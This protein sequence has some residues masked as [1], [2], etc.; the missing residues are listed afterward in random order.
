VRKNQNSLGSS[1]EVVPY[2][3]ANWYSEIGAQ[4]KLFQLEK[5]GLPNFYNWRFVTLTVD[6]LKFNSE[7]SAYEHIKERMRYFIR[8]LKSFL[9]ISELQY[10]WKLE[11][12]ENG[13]PHWHMLINYKRPIDVH[14][15]TRLWSYGRID[16]KRCKDKV[17]PY[18]FKYASKSVEGLPKWFLKYK[19]PRLFQSSGIFQDSKESVNEENE[20]EVETNSSS[21]QSETLGQRLV[22]YSKTVQFK[23]DGKTFSLFHAGCDWMHSFMTLIKFPQVEFVNPFKLVVPSAIIT[24]LTI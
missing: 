22:R 9:N 3:P 8:S 17:F 23:K 15:L 10:A 16:I 12:Q 1:I 6:P 18:T 5:K 24:S 11:F 13:M 20:E 14:E 7:Q 21:P 19:R 4:K 2:Q